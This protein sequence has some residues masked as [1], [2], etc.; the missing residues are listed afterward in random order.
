MRI[1]SVPATFT[2]E[3]A[4]FAGI[5]KLPQGAYAV[6]YL[7]HYGVP[8][9]SDQ[10]LEEAST[11]FIIRLIGKNPHLG[12]MQV[13]DPQSWESRPKD[14]LLTRSINKR[15]SLI[16]RDMWREH[17]S[18]PHDLLAE[19]NDR[20]TQQSLE[21]ELREQTRRKNLR[22]RRL[23]DYMTEHKLSLPEMAQ[24]LGNIVGLFH[25]S[26]DMYDGL[27]GVVL[28]D[29]LKAEGRQPGQIT[30]Q[31]KPKG[32]FQVFDLTPPTQAPPTQEP[33]SLPY[34]HCHP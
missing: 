33:P 12:L 34:P 23:R 16:L 15:L 30:M 31:V 27:A 7:D 24:L 1:S 13:S 10:A 6:T 28:L 17:D 20:Q 22:A 32:R 3:R 5:T 29:E 21:A 4:R 26:R 25:H 14:Y 18:L 19:A 9:T 2:S 8:M 11:D